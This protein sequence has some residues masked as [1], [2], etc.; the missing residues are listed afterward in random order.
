MV[1]PT[2]QFFEFLL[3]Q[4]LHILLYLVAVIV[5]PLAVCVICIKVVL[6]GWDEGSDHSML[7]KLI[8]FKRPQ[9]WEIFDVLGSVE[10]ESI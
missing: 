5:L 3:I 8:P 7:E 2:E 4:Q 9:P 6:V 10:A 1:I